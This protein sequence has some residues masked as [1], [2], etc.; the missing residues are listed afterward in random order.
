MPENPPPP[1][2]S[3]SANPSPTAPA[4]PS[5]LPTTF[6]PPFRA[7]YTLFQ[8]RLKEARSLV[9][10]MTDAWEASD[11][12]LTVAISEHSKHKKILFVQAGLMKPT[13]SDLLDRSGLIELMERLDTPESRAIA[14]DLR[15]EDEWTRRGEK[16]DEEMELLDEELLWVSDEQVLGAEGVFDP[17][18]RRHLLAE[19]RALY[20]RSRK[21]DAIHIRLTTEMRRILLF[22]MRERDF[23]ELDEL[24]KKHKFYSEA[25]SGPQNP[26]KKDRHGTKGRLDALKQAETSGRI[27]ELLA[28]M[29]TVR[30]GPEEFKK[31]A[32]RKMCAPVEEVVSSMD[33]I[34]KELAAVK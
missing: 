10:H 19:Q 9:P 27:M 34:C 5:D 22:S 17:E 15:L 16:P 8:S 26:G 32:A 13:S 23:R 33:A 29:G 25:S 31:E 1:E 12:A 20:A 11:E 14:T 24:F 3:A 21:L 18:A 4:T 28:E 6:E 7:V 2:P 30:A